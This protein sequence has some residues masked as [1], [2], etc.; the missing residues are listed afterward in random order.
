MRQLRLGFWEGMEME[1]PPPPPGLGWRV[2]EECM[3]VGRLLPG[4]RVFLILSEQTVFFPPPPSNASA[5]TGRG[6][7]RGLLP[8]LPSL[9]ALKGEQLAGE[10]GVGGVRPRLYGE[11]GKGGERLD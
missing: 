4:E 11:R 8:V 3:K 1:P 7:W 2:L 9:E 10:G 5:P 6:H